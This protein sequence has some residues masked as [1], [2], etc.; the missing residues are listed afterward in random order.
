MHLQP[1]F[2]ITAT[3]HPP[4]KRAKTYAVI[5]VS[6]VKFHKHNLKSSQTRKLSKRLYIAV[7]MST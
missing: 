1:H 6:I 7:N 4:P 2:N 5:F 3:M